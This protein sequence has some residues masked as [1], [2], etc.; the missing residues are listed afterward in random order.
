VAEAVDDLRDLAVAAVDQRAVVVGR[1]GGV[2]EA[3]GGEGRV[4]VEVPTAWTM[5]SLVGLV[6]RPPEMP[7]PV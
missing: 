4:E 5:S 1:A 3:V 6:R 7:A 2:G